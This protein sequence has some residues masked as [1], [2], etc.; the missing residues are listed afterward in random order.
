MFSEIPESEEVNIPGEQ[1][2]GGLQHLGW[3]SE[4]P[5]KASIVS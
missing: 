3:S 4:E 1:P 5:G 2:V